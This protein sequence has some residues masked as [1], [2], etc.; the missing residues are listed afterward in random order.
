VKLTVFKGDTKD[1]VED[2]LGCYQAGDHS[3]NDTLRQLRNFQIAV[4]SALHSARWVRSAQIRRGRLTGVA[5]DGGAMER[6]EALAPLVSTAR[7]Y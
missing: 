2:Y 6:A 7:F 4:D 1:S 3:L 5:A